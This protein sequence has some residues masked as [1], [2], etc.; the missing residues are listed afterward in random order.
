MT[1]ENDDNEW[2]EAGE[3]WRSLAGLLHR[4]RA[5]ADLL[6]EIADALP[7]GPRPALMLLAGSLLRWSGSAAADFEQ[8]ALFPLLMDRII[9]EGA[10]WAALARSIELARRD[11]RDSSVRGFEL[12]QM[13]DT[14]GSGAGGA[15]TLGLMLR[16]QFEAERCRLDWLE[17]AVLRP[18]RILLRPQDCAAMSEGMALILREGGPCDRARLMV[19]EGAL[20]G[21]CQSPDSAAK[22]SRSGTRTPLIPSSAISPSFHNLV[23]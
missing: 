5:L 19:V 11:A 8:R 17:T 9:A 1:S 16:A 10:P 3:P 4:R 12:A 2:D 14:F 18:A 15:E 6:E 7:V 13:L 23:I 20:R 21:W 22:R